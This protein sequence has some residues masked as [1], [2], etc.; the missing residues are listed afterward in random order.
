MRLLEALKEM[1][2]KQHFCLNALTN[3]R[4]KFE[5]SAHYRSSFGSMSF[6]EAFKS[7][8]GVIYI[9]FESLICFQILA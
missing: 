2:S 8:L 6:P 5:I 7:F 3:A 4:I 1:Y 9:D